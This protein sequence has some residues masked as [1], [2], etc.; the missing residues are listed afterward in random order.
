MILYRGDYNGLPIRL[1]SCNTGRK[2]NGTCVVQE[3]ADL[4]GVPVKAPDNLLITNGKGRLHVGRNPF[5]NTGEFRIFTT[6]EV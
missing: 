4:L 3:L 6:K 5:D 1:L 2:V